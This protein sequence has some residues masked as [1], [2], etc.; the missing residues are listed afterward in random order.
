[1]KPFFSCYHYPITVMCLDDD[2]NLLRSLKILLKK[3]NPV[4]DF[5]SPFTAEAFL[6]KAALLAATEMQCTETHVIDENH[7]HQHLQSIQNLIY[8]ARRFEEIS[9]L[10]VDY[11]MPGMDGLTFCRNFQENA[12]VKIMLTGE[13]DQSLAI[14]AFN[15]G[16]I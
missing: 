9:T 13:A 11:F 16:V 1:M 3:S 4:R 10:V 7:I 12:Y 14:A 6:K 2:L 8:D 15:E 5:F